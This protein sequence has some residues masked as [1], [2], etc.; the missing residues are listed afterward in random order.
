M[1]FTRFY[2]LKMQLLKSHKCYQP[3]KGP[4]LGGY[5]WNKQMWQEKNGIASSFS[6]CFAS[7]DVL[8]G[9]QK[10]LINH[11]TIVKHALCTQT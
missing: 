8:K 7:P 1:H 9:R 5:E 11:K 6:S 2:N 3:R 4:N 10:A